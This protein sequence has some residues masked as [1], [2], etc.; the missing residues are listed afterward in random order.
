MNEATAAP[1]ARS[2]GY[3]WRLAW[4][5][6]LV[7]FASLWF[8]RH[9]KAYVSQT[10]IVG[11]TVTLFGLW[12]LVL[13]ALGVA[14]EKGPADWLR[15]AFTS[16]RASG[17][18]GFFTLLI[19]A[20]WACTSS[21][22]LTYDSDSRGSGSY[23]VEIWQGN[24]LLRPAEVL[25]PHD[26]FVG[27]PYFF[28]FGREDLEFRIA[29]PVGYEPKK[30]SWQTGSQITVPVPYSWDPLELHLVKIVPGKDFLHSLPTTA[31][32]PGL[33]YRLVLAREGADPEDAFVVEPLLKTVV[34]TG[35]PEIEL[36]AATGDA[37]VESTR[38]E[39][40]RMLLRMSTTDDTRPELVEQLFASV[41]KRPMGRLV[42]GDK[43]RI[44]VYSLSAAPDAQPVLKVDQVLEIKDRKTTTHVVTLEKLP[45]PAGGTP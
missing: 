32:S 9:L 43:L 4:F 16:A 41:A 11:G 29:Q 2:A 17:Y 8:E 45:Q 7:V 40:D 23:R 3:R 30:I 34:F 27:Q 19:G 26:K 10:A 6:L 12:K 22:Y 36:A 24:R 15:R 21:I 31:T 25:N 38:V 5:V 37:V 39:V 42:A 33:R 18:L 1:V 13:D 20:L 14:G 28:H 35:M 44:R